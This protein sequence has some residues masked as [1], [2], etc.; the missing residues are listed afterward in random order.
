MVN[1]P[2]F[3]AFYA[4]ATAATSEEQLKKS[5]EGCERA[6]GPAT[7][8]H[9]PGAA[10]SFRFYATMVERVYRTIRGAG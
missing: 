2:V 3:D 9:I 5:N 7:L 4:K 8:H 6:C 1:D 10:L